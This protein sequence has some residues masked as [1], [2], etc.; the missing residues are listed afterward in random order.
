V[1]HQLALGGDEEHG[2][3]EALT[4]GIQDLEVELHVVHVERHVLLRLP[5]DHLARLHLL[6]P[7][8]RDLL[9]DHDPPADGG[10]DLLG[11]DARRRHETLDRVRHEARIHDLTFD[12][13]VVH[14]GGERDLGQDRPARGVRDRHELDEP[15]ADVEAHRRRVAPEESHTSPLVEG[16]EAEA[17]DSPHV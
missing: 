3:L 12:D 15:A 4:L 10:H 16:P 8:H 7:V 6:H 9:D 2:H 11:L 1:L 17:C 5:A 13:R 14:H